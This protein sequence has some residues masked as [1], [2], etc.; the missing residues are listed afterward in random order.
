VA[1]T[2]ALSLTKAPVH[3]LLGGIAKGEDFSVLSKHNFP[4]IA[5][6]YIFGQAQQEISAALNTN[7]AQ[8]HNNLREAFSA[9]Q[10][11]AK[12]G[13]AI[14]LSPGCAS[15]DQFTDFTERGHLFRKLVESL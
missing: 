15:Y 2:K 8:A 10:Q 6:Y 3:L 11:A 13:D 4:N 9:A 5:G 1:V 14:L 7:L 12:A